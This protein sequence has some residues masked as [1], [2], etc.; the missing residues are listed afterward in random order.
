MWQIEQIDE[1]I[2]SIFSRELKV[3][4][5]QLPHE[6]DHWHRKLITDLDINTLTES[7]EDI[8]NELKENQV[9]YK[10][11]HN[12]AFSPL[13]YNEGVNC[14]GTATILGTVMDGLEQDFNVK[15]GYNT[16]NQRNPVMNR[17]MPETIMDYHVW[18]EKENGEEIGDTEDIFYGHE[19][20]LTDGPEALNAINLFRHYTETG[21]Q[22]FIDTYKELDTSIEYVNRKLQETPTRF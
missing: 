15:V 16:N 18:L 9:P 17:D 5:E 21:E 19:Q 3:R 1:D 22:Q 7:P 13:S 14:E 6:I 8:Y 11:K 2:E 12:F 4:P 20:T 10:P